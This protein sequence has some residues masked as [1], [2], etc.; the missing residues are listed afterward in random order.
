MRD[1]PNTPPLTL[2]R[3]R[4]I[5]LKNGLH[6]PYTGNVHD[7]GGASTYCAQCNRRLIERDWYELGAWNL[8]ETG[9]CG[10]CG[11]DCA[12]VFDGRPGEWG[13]RRQAVR[14][15]DFARAL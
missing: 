8:D 2:T 3:A 10:N 14:L 15:K 12:G 9:A 4:H 1:T 7:A 13:R 5:A 6:Y 11:A